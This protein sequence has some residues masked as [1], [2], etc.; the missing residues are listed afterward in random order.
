MAFQIFIVGSKTMVLEQSSSAYIFITVVDFMT[1]KVTVG[2]IQKVLTVASNQVL[3]F[4]AVFSQTLSIICLNSSLSLAHNGLRHS[5]IGC[6][7]C[8]VLL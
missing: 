6:K 8:A 2:I 7:I 5:V 1:D 4:D 3:T